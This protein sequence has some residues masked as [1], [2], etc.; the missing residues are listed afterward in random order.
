MF[1]SDI[2]EKVVTCGVLIQYKDKFLICHATMSPWWSIP[3]G[4]KNKNESLAAAAI[5]ELREETGI[6]LNEN[7]LEF[8]GVFPYTDKKDLALFKYNLNHPID[9]KSLKCTSYF[10]H[11]K[12]KK[13]LPETDSFKFVDLKE[14][15]NK[16][17]KK[18]YYIISE[19]IKSRN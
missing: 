4:I 9:I 5:R 7:Q 13:Q 11:A 16:L 19:V 6:E 2:E 8:A 18:L 14:A 15:K 12:T 10:F 17:N 1:D 3:K